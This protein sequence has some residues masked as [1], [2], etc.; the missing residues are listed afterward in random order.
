M[1]TIFVFAPLVC[2]VFLV[3]LTQG[4]A[5]KLLMVSSVVKHGRTLEF[6][7][8]AALYLYHDLEQIHSLRSAS[9]CSSTKRK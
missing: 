6:A 3:P 5:C 2:F 1:V 4:P 8:W 7:I 9:V